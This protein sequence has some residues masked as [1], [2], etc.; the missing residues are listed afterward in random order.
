MAALR[1]VRLSAEFL[2]RHMAA[3]DEIAKDRCRLG[4]IDLLTQSD[5]LPSID[6]LA[7]H[8]D[9]QP[10]VHAML[11]RRGITAR[12]M[13][14]GTMTLTGAPVEGLRKLH[15]EAVQGNGSVISASNVA[16]YDAHNQAIAQQQ[17]Q[18][19]GGK[20]PACLE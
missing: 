20:S 11:A 12:E 3:G 15:P 1:D 9:P 10:D 17:S 6:Q 8:Y 13:V 2:Q 5:W 18:V 19:N 14:L 7:N 16:F 4:M